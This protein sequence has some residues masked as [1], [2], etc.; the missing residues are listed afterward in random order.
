V[1]YVFIP[2]T[3]KQ[4]QKDQKDLCE[5][6]ASLVY[7]VSS[8]QPGLHREILSQKKTNNKQTNKKKPENNKTPLRQLLRFILGTQSIYHSINPGKSYVVLLGFSR[9]GRGQNYASFT[10]VSMV[11]LRAGPFGRGLASNAQ[12]PEFDPQHL[13]ILKNCLVA[14]ACNPHTSE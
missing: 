5:L 2:I 4:R 13:S 10:C 1:A 11:R 12:S 7:R 9:T 14:W 8:R 3:G 6:E